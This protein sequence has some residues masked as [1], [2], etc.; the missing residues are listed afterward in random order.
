MASV[1][2]GTSAPH[3][4]RAESW[5]PDAQGAGPRPA[6][7]RRTGSCGHPAAAQRARAGRAS[8]GPRGCV[9]GP[10]LQPPSEPDSPPATLPRPSHRHSHH[11]ISGARHGAPRLPAT[12]PVNPAGGAAASPSP[13]EAPSQLRRSPCRATGGDGG[14]LSLVLR[15]GAT[16]STRGW[17]PESLTSA[18]ATAVSG[19]GSSRQRGRLCVCPSFPRRCTPVRAAQL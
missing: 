12:G 14:P 1:E 6:A 19:G 9:C 18:S 2:T 5:R 7:S 15:N 13:A 8:P 11:G 4:H 17:K 10:R 3:V 16:R